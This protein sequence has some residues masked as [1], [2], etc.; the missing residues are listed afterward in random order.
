MTES[1]NYAMRGQIKSPQINY[2]NFKKLFIKT[3]ISVIIAII[4]LCDKRKG[5]KN[6]NRNSRITKRRKKYNV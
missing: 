5:V 1:Q 2:K 4:K 3:K 6:E